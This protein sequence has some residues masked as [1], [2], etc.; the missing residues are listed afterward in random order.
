MDELISKLGIQWQLLIAQ[1]INFAIVAFVL[2]KFAYKPVIEILEKRRSKIEKS[3][4]E[5]ERI[6]KDRARMNEEYTETIKRAREE[7]ESIVTEAKKN[8]EQLLT[9]MRNSAESEYKKTLD[10]AQHDIVE[11]TK[12]A[13]NEIV[14]H[15]AALVAE[16]VAKVTED[17]LTPSHNNALI[18]KTL[19]E[20]R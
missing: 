2:W 20:L 16:A 5:A 15:E 9:D 3:I 12:E 19:K 6:E 8:G 10:R 13:Q 1:I 18:E 14:K 4:A 11:Q 17:A 7:A